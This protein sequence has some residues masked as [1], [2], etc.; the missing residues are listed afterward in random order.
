MTGE[1]Q[2]VEQVVAD[3]ETVVADNATPKVE[4]EVSPESETSPTDETAQSEDVEQPEPKTDKTFTQDEVNEIVQKRLAKESRKAERLARAEA[5]ANL[6]KQQLAQI[7]QPK[8]PVQ[9]VNAEPKLEDFQTYD[10]YVRAIGRFEARQEY[11]KLRTSQEQ[12]RQKAAQ[13]EYEANLLTNIRRG[14]EKYD[15]FD[16][17]V[18]NPS[19]PLTE[20]MRDAAADSDI[21]ADIVYHLGTHMD[22]ASKIAR[23]SPVQQIKAIS[24]LE[25]KLK[26]PPKVTQAP[27]PAQT[28]GKSKPVPEVDLEKASLDEYMAQRRKQGA[29]WAR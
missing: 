14:A 26:A 21:A 15:D 4:Q 8:P 3:N 1:T 27:P 18:A 16:E 17:V 10:E 20:A 28:V 29:R 25:T 19:L 7:Q 9:S 24:A 2:E 12:E 11:E 6:Y 22:E 23:M 13:R 5:E